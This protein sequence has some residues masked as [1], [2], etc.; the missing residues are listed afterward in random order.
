[1]SEPLKVDW[2]VVAGIRQAEIERLAAELSALKKEKELN[3]GLLSITIGQL[4]ERIVSADYALFE[5]E[6]RFWHLREALAWYANSENYKPFSPKN[7]SWNSNAD[8]DEGKRA[9]DALGMK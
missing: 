6:K 7:C 8:D 3:D 1:M 9:R 5:S 4:R 2:C